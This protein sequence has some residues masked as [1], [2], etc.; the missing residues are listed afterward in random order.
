MRRGHESMRP[1]RIPPAPAP[2]S[3]RD[4][5][6]VEA[7]H[8]EEG[9]HRRPGDHDDGAADPTSPE[10]KAP[11]KPRPTRVKRK[12]GHANPRPSP[13]WQHDTRLGANGATSSR[14]RGRELAV[15][16]N[17]HDRLLGQEQCFTRLACVYLEKQHLLSQVAP[18]GRPAQDQA[19]DSARPSGR[20]RPCT[21]GRRAARA[22][23][24]GATR[25]GV[26]SRF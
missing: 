6:D 24:S 23:D 25:K 10:V 2:W 22:I 4:H 21:G 16:S 12:A 19:R 7:A 11:M 18:A 3:H 17:P 5:L 15:R 1:S 8:A 14:P 26:G 13:A 9:A 20:G